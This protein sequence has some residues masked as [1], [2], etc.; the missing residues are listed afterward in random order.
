MP[1]QGTT[2]SGGP[3]QESIFASPRILPLWTVT[4]VTA[5]AT[6][7]D[8]S[9]G[10][11]YP[12]GALADFMPQKD[13]KLESVGNRVIQGAF[14]GDHVHA[15]GLGSGDYL[16]ADYAPFKKY[17]DVGR[18]K[19]E[20]HRAEGVVKN[21]SGKFIFPVAERRMGASAERRRLWSAQRTART[22]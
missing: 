1:N 20:V 4:Q 15:G 3:E 7:K 11:S 12:S 5:D 8:I 13:M 19:V 6:A 16:V 14:I 10:V 2:Q 22:R 9:R 21:L 17:C 18:A